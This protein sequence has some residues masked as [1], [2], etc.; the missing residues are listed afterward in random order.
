MASYWTMAVVK[1]IRLN[2]FGANKSGAPGLHCAPIECL[3][4]VLK[5]DCKVVYIIGIQLFHSKNHCAI[6]NDNTCK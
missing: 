2:M 4:R 5:N 6:D 1:T 3:S